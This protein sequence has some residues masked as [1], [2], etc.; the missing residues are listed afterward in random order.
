MVPRAVQK[1]DVGSVDNTLDERDCA[2]RWELR[3]LYDE[4]TARGASA[5]VVSRGSAA[6]SEPI[7]RPYLYLVNF[8]T[9][10]CRNT[11]VCAK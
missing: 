1:L 7:H 5:R 11:I 4:N 3:V 2:L 10:Q 8:P 6:I 9:T